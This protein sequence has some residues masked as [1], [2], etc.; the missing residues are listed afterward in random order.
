MQKKT[1]PHTGNNDA[2][3]NDEESSPKSPSKS[4]ALSAS[5]KEILKLIFENFY[6]MHAPERAT[7]IPVLVKKA[8][9]P[10]GV[11]PYYENMWS[12]LHKKYDLPKE[13]SLHD[14]MK[15]LAETM[16]LPFEPAA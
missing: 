6:G 7:Q 4:G 1:S 8:D 12:A 11:W 2:A 5:E 3:K 16:G 13:Q 9:T 15:F 10:I 14:E